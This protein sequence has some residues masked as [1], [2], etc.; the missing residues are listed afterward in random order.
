[1]QTLLRKTV[2]ISDAHI[3]HL[4]SREQ[5]LLCSFIEAIKA[6]TATLIMVGDIFDFWV[7]FK[8]V[9]YREY[10]PI[11]N[12]FLE[13]KESGTE[14]IYLEGNHDFHM[15]DFFTDIP[16]SARVLKDRLEMEFDGRKALIEH[17]DRVD[18]KDYGYI[19]LRWFLRTSLVNSIAGIIPPSL[20]LRFARRLSHTSRNYLGKRHHQGEILKRFAMK[21]W[22]EGY[23]IVILGHSH[24]PEF[25]Y[26][27]GRNKLYINLGDWLEHFT[28]LEY[29]NGDFNLKKFTGS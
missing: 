2:C 20:L 7:G 15:G 3:K 13:L 6:D 26:D 19:L 23:D 21:K 29:C 4:K 9:V 28:Y 25:I 27:N 14:I 17:G 24:S 22:N 11:L 5:N 10:I 16:L 18:T 1:M 12:K 8:D